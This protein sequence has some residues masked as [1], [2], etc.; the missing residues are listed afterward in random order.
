VLAI[1]VLL[2]VAAAVS[3]PTGATAS[4]FGPLPDCSF[5]NVLTPYRDYAD[6]SHTLLDTSFKVGRKYVPPRLAP[7]SK[8]LIQGKGQVRR[9]VLRD[10]YNL[11]YAAW[12]AGYPI[13]VV[14]AYRSY[15]RQ[16][17]TFEY[18]VDRVGYKAALKTSARAG[19][20]EHQLGTTLD[21]KAK[22]G[23]DPWMV[24]DWAT[25]PAG[26]W[27]AKNAWK[28]GFVMSYP[29]GKKDVTCYTYEPWHYRYFGR[30]VAERIHKS[31]LT[32]RQWLWRH[33]YVVSG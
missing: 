23:P 20:S 8:A 10:L 3:G 15:N 18:W 11:K 5:D 17:A 2:A 28:Y 7:V 6:W 32:S 12:K 24:D 29:K 14:S 21:F 22:G 26:H 33:G 27:M 31:G 16:D 13:A 19:H 9:F 4:S 1:S 25:T 30:Q